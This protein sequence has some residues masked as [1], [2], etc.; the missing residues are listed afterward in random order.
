MPD[1]LP[2]SA[3]RPRCEI[4]PIFSG[5]DPD[6]KRESASI[7]GKKPESELVRGT[8]GEVGQRRM[9]VEGLIVFGESSRRRALQQ[10]IVHNHEE[11]N[12]QG[13]DNPNPSVR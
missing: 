9:S 2:L 12:H 8:L 10:Y 6:G 1:R 4:L 3:A 11:R 7:A 5:T 13:K